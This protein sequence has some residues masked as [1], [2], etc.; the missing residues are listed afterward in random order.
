MTTVTE[1]DEY[2]LLKQTAPLIK[3]ANIF[4]VIWFVA[5]TCPAVYFLVSHGDEIREFAVVSAVGKVNRILNEQYSGFSDRVLNEV[6][7][8]KYVSKIDV[9]EIKLDKLEHVDEIAG[10]AKK[11]SSVLSKLGVKNAG[12]IEDATVSLQKQV[13]KVN[14]QLETTVDKVKKS[15]DTEVRKGL[16]KEIDSLAETQIRRQLAL[17]EKSFLNLNKGAY[18]ASSADGRRITK[19][20][21]TELASNKKGLFQD[22]IAGAEKYYKWIMAALLLTVFVVTLIPP[23]LVKKLAKKFSATFTQCP[24]CKKVFISKAN[25]FSI[26]KML[27]P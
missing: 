22:A 17:S 27:K 5:V 11:A 21:Y 6:K 18:G 2:K 9:P 15:L 13:D 14:R 16:K 19:E 7:I 20:I 24:H 26:L 12:K 1:G 23:F 25:A 4:F 8:D 3:A 10:K